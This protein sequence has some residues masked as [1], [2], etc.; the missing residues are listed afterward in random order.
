M[1]TAMNANNAY[2]SGLRGIY[3]RPSRIVFTNHTIVDN[4]TRIK[5]NKVLLS[6]VLL[7]SRGIGSRKNDSVA[8]NINADVMSTEP[9]IF[10]IMLVSITSAHNIIVAGNDHRRLVRQSLLTVTS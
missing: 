6:S 10:L 7:I 9:N 3:K 1:T 5:S 4:N 2:S 8:K